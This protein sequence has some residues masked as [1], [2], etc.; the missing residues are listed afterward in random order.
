MDIANKEKWYNKLFRILNSSICFSLAY[1][2]MT[3]GGYFAMGLVG[4][5]FKFDANIYYYGVRFLL[6]QNK[7]TKF[8]ITLIFTTY[9]F[10]ALIFG[11]LMLYL[12]SKIKEVRTVLNL[13]FV[14]CFVIGSSIFVSQ[15][16]VATMGA[17]EFNSPF[18]QHFSVV[19]AWWF[20]PPAFVYALNLPF[21][22][23]FLYFTI[24]YPKLF[25]RFSY[26]YSKV[27][28]VSRRRKYFAEIAIVPFIIGSVATTILTFPM[29]I[30]MHFV[31]LM[32]ISISLIIGWVALHYLEM[33]RDDVLRYRSLQQ[34][35]Y[36]LLIAVILVM[37]YVV[38]TW[39]GI[40]LSL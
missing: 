27:N 34:F 23:L 30:F 22:V 10:F 13:F 6:N 17:N 8:K 4:K 9:P 35:N 3:Y 18:Y 33:M 12:F 39:R 32:F 14:W 25:L 16:L 19:F 5:V 15:G 26:S 40:F 11:L 28:K 24:H 21:I 37:G 1:T 7:W 29:N 20:M 36:F 2:I 31:Y 38:V